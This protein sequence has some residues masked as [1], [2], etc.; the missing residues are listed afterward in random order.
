ML[1]TLHSLSVLQEES[2]I[3]LNG[4]H[5]TI[6]DSRTFKSDKSMADSFTAIKE[7]FF[8][9]WDGSLHPF[10][11]SLINSENK[12]KVDPTKNITFIPEEG[13]YLML[14]GL[15]RSNVSYYYSIRG[16]RLIGLSVDDD[17]NKDNTLS[18]FNSPVYDPLQKEYYSAITVILYKNILERCKSDL[19][20]LNRV[21]LRIVNI[22]AVTYLDDQ[23]M[24]KHNVPCNRILANSITDSN[25]DAIIL[26]ESFN[27]SDAVFMISYYHTLFGMIKG[28]LNNSILTDFSVYTDTIY[29]PDIFKVNLDGEDLDKVS[30]T[31]DNLSDEDAAE[32]VMYFKQKIFKRIWKL[33]DSS[34]S[35]ITDSN[36]LSICHDVFTNLEVNLDMTFYEAQDDAL[37]SEENTTESEE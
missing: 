29:L 8:K 36:Y 12:Y 16:L 33:A 18:V 34:L 28:I 4:S 23:L 37:Q 6:F 7:S 24:T 9:I 17:E 30:E 25:K 32:Y 3:V 5:Y 13:I 2:N 11:N 15:D 35:D 19:D 20:L 27:I 22:V 21:L 31:L 10:I 1:H 26:P 14:Q